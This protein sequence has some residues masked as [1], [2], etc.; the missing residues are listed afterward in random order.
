MWRTR[1]E[2][3]FVTKNFRPVETSDKEFKD[4]WDGLVNDVVHVLTSEQFPALAFT[5]RPRRDT[6]P[7]F[8]TN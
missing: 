5:A 8:V 1:Q 7:F 4:Q 3:R 6:G 2:R